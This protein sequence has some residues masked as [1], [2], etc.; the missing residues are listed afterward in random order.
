MHFNEIK[1][2]II[3]ND[4][5]IKNEE[6]I[7]DKYEGEINDEK[8][9]INHYSKNSA[10]NYYNTLKIFDVFCYIKI[11]QKNSFIFPIKS[12][13]LNLKTQTV[14]DLIKNIVKKFNENKINIKL[15]DINYNISLKDCE[16]ENNKN[17]YINN[18][19]LRQCKKKDCSPKFDLPYYSDK[20]LLKNI[21]NEKL[22]FVVKDS[23]NI[24]I[25]EKLDNSLDAK[26]NETNLSN[27]EEGS[28][29]KF[30]E[31]EKR[32]YKKYNSNL[33]NFN[34]III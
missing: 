33:C 30:Y 12:D 7:N 28:T 2:D 22:S 25:I 34:C 23:V 1:N 4:K 31:K 13:L 26:F 3:N 17:F 20:S 19:E 27:I 32:R 16:N 5:D 24:M 11:N 29:E 18:Y 8:Y 15:N 21:S 9:E 6:I 10:M 14:N